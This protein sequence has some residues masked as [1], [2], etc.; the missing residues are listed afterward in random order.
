VAERQSRGRG[1]PGSIWHSP[2]GGLYFSVIIKPRKNPQDLTPL[3]RL[4][5]QAV[6]SVI[7]KRTGLSAR[8]KLP[9]D[10][11]LN[12]KKIC[13]ILTEKVGDAV[14]VG[15]GMNLNIPQFP[16]QLKATS[17]FLE[18]KRKWDADKF[19]G[20]LLTELKNEY[21]NFLA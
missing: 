9:N 8:I 14:I 16:P 11:L 10:I 19:L 4:A 1:K 15:I 3:T 6:V 17:L 13:G 21:V 7:E 12:R 18:S 20:D 2:A 5:A